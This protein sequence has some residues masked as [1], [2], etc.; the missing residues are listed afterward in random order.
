MKY[1]YNLYTSESLREKKLQILS[2]INRGEFVINKYLIV[3]TQNEKNHLE[4]YDSAFVSQ[5]VV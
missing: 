4:F 1:Y 3:L 2:R 5:K